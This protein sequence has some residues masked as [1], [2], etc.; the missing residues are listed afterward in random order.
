VERALLFKKLSIPDV[1]LV[2]V[3]AFGDNRGYFAEVYKRSVFASIGIDRPVA[4]LNFSHPV[5][6]SSK[7]PALS[8]ETF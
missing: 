7:R 2:E 3:A 8:T 4:Q 1:V 6:G 5:K